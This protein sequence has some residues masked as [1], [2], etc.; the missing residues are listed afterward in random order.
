MSLGISDAIGFILVC[1]VMV[2]PPQSKKLRLALEN[3]CETLNPSSMP[4]S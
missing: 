4:Q 3:A 1:L 2:F